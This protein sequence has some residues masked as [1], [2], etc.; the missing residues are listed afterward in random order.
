MHGFT[1]SER[2]FY[3]LFSETKLVG[4]FLLNV[5]MTTVNHSAWE[6]VSPEQ[7]HHQHRAQQ[8]PLKP[9]Q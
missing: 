9:G 7:E 8:E 3:L 4:Q 1:G 5:I 6:A 2:V